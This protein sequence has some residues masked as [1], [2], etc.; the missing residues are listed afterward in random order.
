MESV[1]FISLV[2]LFPLV[3]MF[4]DFEEI[5]FIQWWERKNKLVLIKK[6]PWIF[7]VVSI[8]LCTAA[9]SLAVSEEFIILVLI[10]LTSIIFKWY[11]LWFGAF[12]TFFV[13]LIMHLI[14]WIAF[15][16]YIPAIATAIPSMIYSAYTI[17]YIYNICKFNLLQLIMWS[18]LSII[19]FLINLIFVHKLAGRFNKF[20]ND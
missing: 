15:K 3:F 19:F 18:I 1:K 10:T 12:I 5:I 8:D 7:K 11:Y 17:Y 6:Y 9:F 20:I 4:H 2:W 13:H 14:Q 16:K